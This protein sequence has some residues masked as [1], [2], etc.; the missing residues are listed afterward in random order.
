[1]RIF[2]TVLVIILGANLGVQLLDSNLVK[3]LEER[4]QTIENIQKDLK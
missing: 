2:F 1:M 4:K 3:I